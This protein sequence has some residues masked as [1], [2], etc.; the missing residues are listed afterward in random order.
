MEIFGCTLNN[1]T[2]DEITSDGVLLNIVDN[3]NYVSYSDL[4]SAS[5]GTGSGTSY[6]YLATTESAYNNFF[7]GAEVEIVSGSGIGQKGVCTAYNGTTKK[8]DI[9]ENWSVAADTTSVYHIGEVGHLKSYFTDYRRIDI[10]MPD[11]T[12]TALLPPTIALPY[13]STPPITDTYTFTTGDGVYTVVLTSVPT[14]SAT[15]AYKYITTPYVYYNGSI[16]KNLQD[17]LNNIPS[18][19]ATYWEVVSDIT[20]LPTKYRYTGY[21]AVYCGIMSCYL[22]AMYVAETKNECLG[23]NSEQFMRDTYIQRAFKLK[24]VVDSIP[25]LASVPD[26]DKVRDTINY[27]K[28]ICC[29]GNN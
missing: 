2:I 15:V 12:T 23:C 1:G 24:L 20:Q 29:C 7:L 21:I 5:G 6:L 11:N 13:N 27:A 16:Y 26:W 3:S 25:I 19:S 10:T 18:S 14:W 28:N 9:G 4:C 17:S 22:S 8:F